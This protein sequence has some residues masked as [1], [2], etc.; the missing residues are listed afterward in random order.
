MEFSEAVASASYHNSSLH[1]LFINVYRQLNQNWT[2]TGLA[3]ITLVIQ[4]LSRPP[5]QLL[6]VKLA[7][8]EPRGSSYILCLCLTNEPKLE[9][10]TMGF[11]IVVQRCP[12]AF[13]F[14]SAA[15]HSPRFGLDLTSLASAKDGGHLRKVK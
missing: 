13:A 8:T 2:G 15:D 14:P 10:P 3:F 5:W 12:V 1:G 11:S 7:K 6:K 4:G 9:I